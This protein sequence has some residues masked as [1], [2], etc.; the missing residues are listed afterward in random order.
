MTKHNEAKIRKQIIIK[1]ASKKSPLLTSG[2]YSLRLFFPITF[3]KQMK[4]ESYPQ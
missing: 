2:I 3:S 4:S 1:L